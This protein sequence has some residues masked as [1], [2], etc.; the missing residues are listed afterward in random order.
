MASDSPKTEAA[1]ATAPTTG[2]ATTKPSA[3]QNTGALERVVLRNNFY[4]DNYRRLM[5]ICLGL[6]VLTG[7]LGGW[8]VYEQLNKPAPQYFATTYD[9]KLIPIIPLS[10][11]SLNDNQLQQWAV[12]AAVASYSFDYVNYRKSLQESRIYFTKTGYTYF[13]KALKDSN[14]LEAVTSKKMIVS[15]TPTGAA[16]ILNKGL[17]KDGEKTLY[18]WQ[19]QLP[20]VINFQ[21]ETTPITQY[22][23]LNMTIVRVSTLE[24]PD[25]VGIASYVIREGKRS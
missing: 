18:R 22:V 19:V 6:I 8:A 1:N 3:V 9:G 24:S 20:M 2:T 13:L 15:A 4:R 5:V 23:I 16:I 11:P 25:G 17:I 21:S 10:E 7:C 12:E 14:N